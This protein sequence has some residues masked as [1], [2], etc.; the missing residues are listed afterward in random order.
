LAHRAYEQLSEFYEELREDVFAEDMRIGLA[1]AEGVGNR[2]AA[3]RKIDDLMPE[4]ARI[5]GAVS[6]EPPDAEVLRAEVVFRARSV[7]F[8][9]YIPRKDGGR[10]Y[11][12]KANFFWP[13]GGMEFARGNQHFA[14]EVTPWQALWI[15]LRAWSWALLRLPAFSEHFAPFLIAA[16]AVIVGATYEVTC[17]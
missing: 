17:D 8:R 2:L 14:M 12:L 15:R 7:Q 16:I 13:V 6:V 1:R 11:P 9:G 3:A 10:K 5:Y 4:S